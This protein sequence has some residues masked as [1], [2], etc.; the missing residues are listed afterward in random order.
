[1][2]NRV[3]LLLVWPPQVLEP[4][5]ENLKHLSGSYSNVVQ[6]AAQA[7]GHILSGI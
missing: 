4:G 6:H 5:G 3:N 7:A 1:M 2:L